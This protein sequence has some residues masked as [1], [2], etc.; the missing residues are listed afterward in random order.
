[1]GAALGV[2]VELG[3]APKHQGEHDLG[4]EFGLEMRFGLDRV[5]SATIRPLLAHLGDRVALAFGP[6][7]GLHLTWEHLAVAAKRPSVA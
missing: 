2:E 1:M 3:G 5:G 4:E 6:G 7:P